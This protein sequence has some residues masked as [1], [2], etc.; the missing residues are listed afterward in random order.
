MEVVSTIEK[1]FNY[2]RENSCV[3]F[4]NYEKLLHLFPFER[5]NRH[6]FAK[7]LVFY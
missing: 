2:L 6:K 7:C 3:L 4:V 1:H 5:Y